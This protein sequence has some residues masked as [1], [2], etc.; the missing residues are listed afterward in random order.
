MARAVKEQDTDGE[1]L[2]GERG[3]GWFSSAVLQSAAEE[4][5]C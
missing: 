1:F 3:R 5:L 4:E 2:M